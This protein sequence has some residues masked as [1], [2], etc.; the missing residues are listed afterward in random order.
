MHDDSLKHVSLVLNRCFSTAQGCPSDDE[1]WDWQEIRN[2]PIEEIAD[3]PCFVFLWCGSRRSA[4]TLMT[5]WVHI[6]VAAGELCPL[7]W[8]I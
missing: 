7:R 3:T 6:T 2:L 1:V 8:F 4:A 5:A